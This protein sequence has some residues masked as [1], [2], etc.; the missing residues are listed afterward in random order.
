MKTCTSPLVV[1][2]EADFLLGEEDEP[3]G[4]LDLAQWGQEVVQVNISAIFWWAV[5]HHVGLELQ[6]AVM[7]LNDDYLEEVGWYRD[8]TFSQN[9]KFHLSFAVIFTWDEEGSRADV[10]ALVLSHKF[11]TDVTLEVKPWT[12]AEAR[13]NWYNVGHDLGFRTCLFVEWVVGW[14][15][16]ET[17]FVI[18]VA[19]ISDIRA[20]VPMNTTVRVEFGFLNSQSSSIFIVWANVHSLVTWVIL[21]EFVVVEVFINPVGDAVFSVVGDNEIFVTQRLTACCELWEPYSFLDS[22]PYVY[23]LTRVYSGSLDT[24]KT[25]LKT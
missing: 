12:T 24:W 5:G 8:F 7:A 1:A 10:D 14:V 18:G 19:V 15:S 13:N 17:K 22:I 20:M 16:H 11:L 9:V 6:V 2:G 3:R 4:M 23:L 21:E 25:F